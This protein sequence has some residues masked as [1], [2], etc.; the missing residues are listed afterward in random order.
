[1][2][3]ANESRRI[4]MDSALPNRRNQRTDRTRSNR[5]PV[6]HTY[7][8]GAGQIQP[9]ILTQA[10]VCV[11]SNERED[12]GKGSTVSLENDDISQCDETTSQSADD[13]SLTGV[14]IAH[15]CPYCGHEFDV[16]ATHRMNYKQQKKY[17][18]AKCQPEESLQ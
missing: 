4:S 7:G 10:S 2:K 11:E 14:V 13:E 6:G 16:A 1:M 9:G 15:P 3:R 17:A 12:I 8:D 18:S 5:K